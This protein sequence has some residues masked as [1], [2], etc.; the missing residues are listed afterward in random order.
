LF[1]RILPIEMKK[2]ITL[3]NLITVIVSL[4][5]LLLT[6]GISV[7]VRLSET[8]SNTNSNSKYIKELK[9]D[10]DNNSKL[11]DENFKIIIDKLDRILYNEIQQRED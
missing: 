7:N 2:E 1:L 9:E 4:V 11:D 6:W 3:G 5:V 10:V 8:E